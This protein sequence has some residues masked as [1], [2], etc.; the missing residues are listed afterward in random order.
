MSLSR[1]EYLIGKYNVA[2]PRY[3]SYPTVPFWDV[4]NFNAEVWKNSLATFGKEEIS[5][6]QR[7]KKG[8]EINLSAPASGRSSRPAYLCN[9]RVRLSAT[10]I[11]S[12]APARL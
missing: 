5:E 7:N 12:T 9:I 6:N 8:A 1:K 11:S 2:G 3:T 4:A 10:R